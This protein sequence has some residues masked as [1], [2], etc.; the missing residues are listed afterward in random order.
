MAQAQALR[1]N[2]VPAVAMV[3][4]EPLPLVTL[5][6]LLPAAA[7]AAT[8]ANSVSLRSI[9]AA[10][11]PPSRSQESR[12]PCVLVTASAGADAVA[13]K[14]GC[15]FADLPGRYGL[16]V[17]E[18]LDT[19]IKTV[20]EHYTHRLS[21]LRLRF[22]NSTQLAPVEQEAADAATK[23]VVTRAGDDPNMALSCPKVRDA[24]TAR[25]F[26]E[27][28][29]S[30]APWVEE[31]RRVFQHTIRCS[32]HEFFEQPVVHMIALSSAEVDAATL[33][34]AFKQLQQQTPQP[35][36]IAQNVYSGDIPLYYVVVHDNATSRTR[37]AELEK[38]LQGLYGP[39]CSRLLQVNSGDEATGWFNQQDGMTVRGF[40]HDFTSR[41]V[42]PCMERKI[43]TLYA[44]IAEHRKGFGNSLK[45]WFGGAQKAERVGVTLYAGNTPPQYTCVALESQIRLFADLTFMLEDYDLALK[46]YRMVRDD[47][48]NDKANKCYAGAME[49][50][51]VC[52][53][54]LGGSHREI[55]ANLDQAIVIYQR[56]RCT[57][58]ATRATLLLFDCYKL[59]RRNLEASRVLLKASDHETDN[60]CRA[61]I[62]LELAGYC[63]LQMS[64]SQ[65]RKYAF[66]LVLA[67]FRYNLAQE[68][69][70]TVRCYSTA[71]HGY[72]N[73]GWSHIE[74]HLNFAL[75]RQGKALED[76][77]SSMQYLMM[78]LRNC[79]QPAERQEFFVKEF[80]SVASRMRLE[81]AEERLDED[82]VPPVMMPVPRVDD[83]ST[84][85]NVNVGSGPARTSSQLARLPSTVAD[86][87]RAEDALFGAMEAALTELYDVVR[88]SSGG[89]MVRAR[90]AGGVVNCY[91]GEEV[92]VEVQLRNPLRAELTLGDL[93]LVCKLSNEEGNIPAATGFAVEKRQIGLPP[94][95]DGEFHDTST[96]IANL[97]D[98]PVELRVMPKA[99][100][101][102][103]IEGLEWKLLNELPCHHKFTL[104]GSR[105]NKTKK[106][107]QSATPEYSVDKRLELRVCPPMPLLRATFSVA[108]PSL[109]AGEV[110]QIK[111]KLTNIGRT[112]NMESVTVGIS[113]PAFCF[114]SD[115]V[116]DRPSE[117][118]PPSESITYTAAP[119]GQELTQKYSL[120]TLVG[121]DQRLPPDGSAEFTL[122]LY[123][124]T[125]GDHLVSFLFYYDATPEHS[126]VNF[127]T[128][129]HSMRVKVAPALALEAKLANPLGDGEAGKPT[130]CVDLVNSSAQP[131]VMQTMS[132]ISSCRSPQSSTELGVLPATLQSRQQCSVQVTMEASAPPAA[133]SGGAADGT[134]AVEPE[135]EPVVAAAATRSLLHSRLPLAGL[136]VEG[137]ATMPLGLTSA[138]PA[139]QFILRQPLEARWLRNWLVHGE[140]EHSPDVAQLGVMWCKPATPTTGPP[141]FGYSFVTVALRPRSW[142]ELPPATR[143]LCDFT[144]APPEDEAAGSSGGGG[145]RGD[146]VVSSA[147]PGLKQHWQSRSLLLGVGEEG[148]KREAV[149]DELEETRLKKAQRK[150]D[151]MAL[152]AA[153][154]EARYVLPNA[155]K[156]QLVS[157]PLLSSRLWMAMTTCS[158]CCSTGGSVPVASGQVARTRGP[159]RKRRR[160]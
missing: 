135:P 97:T 111:L 52:L 141:R 40:M 27:Q 15:S 126:N 116:N 100:G 98:G 77:P 70:H 24:A 73:N 50:I 64:P 154:N 119:E 68:R 3:S 121:G 51:G 71:L 72:N 75:G 153:K 59:W 149:L 127:R 147:G 66:Y 39:G 106:H 89:P 105:L 113:H 14:S 99:E 28:G 101:N 7:A 41:Y 5:R 12:R 20:H 108:E 148:A 30:P 137:G 19:D 156:P 84:H 140:R 22:I 83:E 152:M 112:A 118:P 131:L 8:H 86:D 143:T 102:L 139:W 35:R 146:S 54:Y 21:A 42:V 46:H 150:A 88:K 37:A 23:A 2:W 65:Y 96:E 16:N 53:L 115:G 103:T 58:F 124:T 129:R 47:Y 92:L 56:E 151:E 117:P 95:S 55:E 11:P 33:G 36:I 159:P 63:Y 122:W 110:T 144:V 142:T 48:K 93:S 87:V 132:C 67:G 79:Q 45:S 49:M 69:R 104:R 25:D 90:K 78:L 134:A 74:D 128:L 91:V 94:Q 61:A 32:E 43:R 4:A 109:L 6:F 130:V 123:G 125:P 17:V 82:D 81:A 136:G 145:G 31:Y 10:R 114:I 9:A 138:G 62:M 44:N 157:S 133:H 38:A 76:F 1:G 160:S 60:D 85:I 155:F 26:Q 158:A 34:D 29:M 120:V 13:S 57:T 80:V 18:G 107:R